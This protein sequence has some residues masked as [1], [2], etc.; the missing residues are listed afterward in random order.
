MGAG[1]GQERT[2]KIHEIGRY[3]EAGSIIFPL[4]YAPEYMSKTS[5][6]PTSGIRKDKTTESLSSFLPSKFFCKSAAPMYTA[7]MT[8]PAMGNSTATR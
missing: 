5:A 2:G 6:T 1:R 3:N 8:M 7:P 4:F